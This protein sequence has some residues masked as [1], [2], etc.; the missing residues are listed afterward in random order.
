[1][2]NLKERH[3]FPGGNS[4]KGFFSFYKY[5]ISQEDASR[6][7]CMKG[8]PGTGK[9]HLMKKIGS[10][11]A[12]KN[13]TIEY[14]HCSSDNNSLD[15]VVI[16]ELK[17]AIIDG[18]S[19]H[20]VDPI[21]PGAVDEILNMGEALDMDALLLDKSKIMEVQKEISK[22]FNR[23]YLYLAAAKSIHDDWSN[24]NSESVNINKIST[25][26]ESINEEIFNSQKYGH[27][28]E[29]HL[30]CTAFTP[31]GI[32]SFTEDLVANLSNK[33]ILCG[34]PGLC[35]TEI[36]KKIGATAQR[37]G[38][39]V[40]YMHDPFIPDRIEH[41]LI[42]ELSSCVLTTNEISQISFTGKT[43]NLTDFCNKDIIASNKAEVDACINTFYDLIEKAIS[44]IKKAHEIH[45]D[46]ESFYISK[47]NFNIANDIFNKV[48]AKFEKFENI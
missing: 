47:M 15:A 3:L 42:P 23:A 8:G 38:Y 30:F 35:K 13:Y 21:H 16:K 4:S 33:F 25:V 31:N 26:A 45:D 34:G 39:F 43:F 7:L 36:L 9:S 6:I 41:I 24:L 12:A 10:H 1:M 20:M 37:K 14:H 40:E 18:T 22:N 17:L 27:G 19:P 32:V 11:F 29:R 28:Q 44:L 5:I 48:V 2:D 46:L